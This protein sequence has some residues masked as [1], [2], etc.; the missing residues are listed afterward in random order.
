[1]PQGKV[2]V[3]STHKNYSGSEKTVFNN[4]DLKYG[5]WSSNGRS[6]EWLRYDFD[7]G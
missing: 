6:N 3:S 2:S 5:A 4:H 1:M 7:N